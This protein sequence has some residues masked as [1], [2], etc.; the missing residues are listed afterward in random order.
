M[1]FKNITDLLIANNNDAISVIEDSDVIMVTAEHW[2]EIAKDLK[3]N[4]DLTFDY[5]SCVTGYDNGVGETLGVAYNFYSTSKKHSLE[6]RIE[7]SRENPEIPSIEKIWKT[8]DWMEREVFD[9]YGIN[10]TDHWD[11]RRILLPSDW[12]GYPLRKDYKEPDY[13]NGMP[14]PKDKSYWE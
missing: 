9:L 5:L 14:V 11:L 7:V 1:D 3:D 10:F 2:L 13:Y 4:K 12:V 8:A 6:I